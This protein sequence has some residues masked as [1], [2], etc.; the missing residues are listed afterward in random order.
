M[1]TCEAPT[2]CDA[3]NAGCSPTAAAHP[4][5]SSNRVAPSRDAPESL[6]YKSSTTTSAGGAKSLTLGV[7][8][9]VA[10]AAA[11]AAA[12][13]AAEEEETEEEEEEE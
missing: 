13:A 10:P 11:A 3:A 8:G 9:P 5:P 1:S 7:I 4:L 2:S 12:E 6:L